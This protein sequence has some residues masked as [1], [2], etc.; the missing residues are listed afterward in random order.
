MIA[1]ITIAE[2]LAGRDDY[3]MN[4]LQAFRSGLIEG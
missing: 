3:C 2:A 1:A 4:Y